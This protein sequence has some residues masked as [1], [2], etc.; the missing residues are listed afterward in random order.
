MS[1]QRVLLGIEAK[2]AQVVLPIYPYGLRVLFI[3]DDP[4]FGVY[5]IPY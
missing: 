2:R 4:L 5:C 3:A 1:T